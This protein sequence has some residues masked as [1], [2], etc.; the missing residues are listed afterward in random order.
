MSSFEPDYDLAAAL[1]EA[2]SRYEAN[3]H[4]SDSESDHLASEDERRQKRS[5]KRSIVL[6]RHAEQDAIWQKPSYDRDRSACGLFAIDFHR[7]HTR[8][9]VIR[10]S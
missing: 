6:D 3:R 4:P 7:T 8:R 5:D 2:E 10:I 1:A 9:V